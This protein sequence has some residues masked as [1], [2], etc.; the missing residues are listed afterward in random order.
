MRKVRNA[1]FVVSALIE[2]G[3]PGLEQKKDA[4]RRFVKE[5]FSGKS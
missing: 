1:S 2:H 5:M 4:I 3:N